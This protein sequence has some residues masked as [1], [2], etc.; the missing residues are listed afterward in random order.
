M[1]VVFTPGKTG[2][3]EK[4]RAKVWTPT[5]QAMERTASTFSTVPAISRANSGSHWRAVVASSISIIFPIFCLAIRRP[6]ASNPTSFSPPAWQT[7]TH[8]PQPTSRIL[9]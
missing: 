5:P 6:E 9:L 4:W 2:V 3:F 1:K 7:V 8:A